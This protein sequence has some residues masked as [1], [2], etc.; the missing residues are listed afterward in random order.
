M[1]KLL[2]TEGNP[3]SGAVV[4]VNKNTD[5]LMMPAF[6]ITDENGRAVFHTTV[7]SSGYDTLTFTCGDASVILQ[8][9]VNPIGTVKPDKP[10]ANIS[11]FD[12]VE[13]G[14]QLVISCGTEGAIIRYTLD[15]TCPC[16]ENALVYTGPI[17]ITEDTFVRIAAWSE[18]GGYSER[19]NL[20]ITCIKPEELTFDR[21]SLTLQNNIKVNFFVEKDP[22]I[23]GGFTGLYTVFEMNGKRV[24]VSDY[25]EV[26]SQ[27]ID[28]YVFSFSNIAPNLMNDRIEATLYAFIDETE[29]SGNTIEYS[30][31]DYCY[32]MLESTE[33]QKMRTLIV[34]LLNYGAASQTYTGYNTDALVN[35][36]LTAEQIAWGTAT[37]PELESHT[38]GEYITVSDPAL[39]WTG[40]SLILNDS[41]TMKFIF[42]VESIDGVTLRIA[43]KNNDIIA[44][45]AAEE[46]KK[47]GNSYI[48]KFKGLNAGQMSEVVYITAYREDEAI[49]NTLSYSIESYVAAK[50]HDEDANLAALVTAM[51]KY[52]NSAYAYAH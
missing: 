38:D 49:S 37:D 50:Q 2:D 20:H 19:L 27:G 34:D 3:M 29:Y 39:E 1:I 11:D 6:A 35:D 32:A 14:T 9:Y 23:A 4:T 31:S 26:N 22:I 30:V 10:T 42:T 36:S 24:T 12:A 16:D 44:E 18:T 48:A 25:R 15:N 7:A 21:A 43:D 41:V 13:S 51:M 46:I 28:Y 52:G 40:V 33:D 5:T 8:T 45:I 47:S 17:T